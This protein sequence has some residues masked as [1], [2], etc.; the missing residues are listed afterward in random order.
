MQISEAWLRELVNPAISSAELVAQLTMAGLEIDSITPVA[1]EFSGVVVGE[2]LEM[3]KHPDADKLRVCKVAV[4]EA[5]PLQ[6]VCGASNVRVGLKIPAALCGAVLP[7]DFKIKKSKLRGVESFGMLCSEKELGLADDAQ[8]LMELAADAPVGTNIRDYLQLNDNVLEVDL[9]PNRADCLSVE[10]LAREVAVLNTLDWSPVSFANAQVSH[11]DTLEIKISA[12]EACP[13]YLGRLIKGVNPKAEVPLWMVEKLRRSGQRSLGIL[14][15][16]TNYV[17]LEL[18]QPLHAFD[19]AKLTG[20][21][22]VRYGNDGEELP[23][24]NDQTIKLDT[25]SLVIA[26]DKQALALAGV[27]GGSATAVSDSTT[28]VFL[29]CAFFTPALIAGKARKFGLH[30]DSSHRFERGVDPFLQ[31]RAIERA[32]QLIVD[33]AG[34]SVGVINEVTNTATV[35]SR[36]P[37]TLRKQRLA[38]ILSVEFADETVSGIFQRL[39]MHVETVADGWQVTPP[40]FRFDISIEADLI[41]EVARI[42]G[43]NQLPSTRLLL[44][45]E[46]G[47]APEATLTLERVQDLLVD[48]GYQEAIT[49]SF[50]DEEIQQLIAPNETV[51]RL[52]NPIS[53]EL[54]VMRTSLWCGLLRAA[55]YNTNRQQNR[56]RLFETGLRF[57]NVDGETKQEKMLAGLALGSVNTEQWGEKTRKVDFF[58]MKADIEALSS[59]VACQF[60]YTAAKHPALHPGQ[61]AKITNAAG[62]TVG[63]MGM[64]HPT[65]EKKLGFDH[66]VFL[67]ELNQ[68]L[69]LQRQV[70]RFAPLSKF[71]SVRRDMALIVNENISAQQ[72]I[73]CIHACNETTIQKVMI[74]DIYRGQGIEANHKSVAVSL[75]L[76]NFTQTLTDSEID[77]IFSRV[78]E[79]LTRTIGAKLRD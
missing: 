49:Y 17:L 8:G 25:E 23:L 36:A 75:Q 27:M 69:I 11:Q 39:G 22:T 31:H 1:A 28:D 55:L 38:K 13:R 34:G 53:S 51:V 32:T 42:V 58:D 12:A 19:A 16:V 77:A 52:Q 50:V 43:Y 46:L 48:K 26:D 64:L 3:E 41:E 6:I 63:W 54:S 21:I 33:I 35:P 61:S 9:T 40:G 7:G 14:V 62:E 74:F 29:E 71:P 78:L 72:I 73:D 30:T 2:V 79:T 18:G 60:T 47:K 10:G 66:Q 68:D 57:I 59:L 56:V 37:V 45:S 4:G 70:P 24:L 15:D 20:A 65:L 76:Q 44:R 5:E 67:F